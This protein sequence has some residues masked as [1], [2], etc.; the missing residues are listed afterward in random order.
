M[1]DILKTCD[2]DDFGVFTIYW[3]KRTCEMVGMDGIH[4]YDNKVLEAEDVLAALRSA[5]PEDAEVL[6]VV[7]WE[8][9]QL[10]FYDLKT[11]EYEVMG[12]G[13]PKDDVRG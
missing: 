4:D 2:A 11:F 13:D 3:A 8:S 7:L 12:P 9:G 5:P 10:A 1:G 6:G